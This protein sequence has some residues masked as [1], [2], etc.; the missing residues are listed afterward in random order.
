MIS[1]KKLKDINDMKYSGVYGVY[2]KE[3]DKKRL[4]LHIRFHKRESRT[5][6]KTLSDKKELSIRTEIGTFGLESTFDNF[7]YQSKT[8]NCYIMW[9]EGK[10]F[11]WD[12]RQIYSRSSFVLSAASADN[13]GRRHA[14]GNGECSQSTRC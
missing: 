2:M 10:P 9:T 11:V 4:A 8:Q 7:Y 3:K 1:R 14:E 13:H 6:E 12:G 5:L